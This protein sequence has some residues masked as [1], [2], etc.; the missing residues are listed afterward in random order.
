[1]TIKMTNINHASF[2][3]AADWWR[4]IV[5]VYVIPS[6]NKIPICK[7]KEYLHGEIVDLEFHEH[8]KRHND[9]KGG[10]TAVC[11]LMD[12][13]NKVSFIGIDLDNLLAI[14]AFC[15]IGGKQLSLQQL[16]DTGKFLVCPNQGSMV[17]H[18]RTH[19]S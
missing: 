1:M 7:H 16:A 2:N 4:N 15:N 5:K 12:Y 9:F 13:P 8:W 18:K 17:C 6:N 3:D 10:I 19:D 11:G 14:Q